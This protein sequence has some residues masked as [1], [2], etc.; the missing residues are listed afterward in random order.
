VVLLARPELLAEPNAGAA[1]DDVEAL[2]AR[3]ER[4]G[5]VRAD[6]VST[7]RI[8][9]L[10]APLESAGRLYF[11]PPSTMVRETLHPGV[12]KVVVEGHRVA[13][14]DETGIRRLDLSHNAAAEG[15]VDNL[16]IVLRGDLVALRDRFEIDYTS[17]GARWRLA[18]T[19]L[20][21]AVRALIEEIAFEGAGARLISM[22]TLETNGDRSDLDFDRVDLNVVLDPGER[23]ALLSLEATDA[24]AEPGR[25]SE[26]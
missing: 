3:F 14:R 7:Q 1:P 8:T 26:P 9:L 20:S 11:E 10:L 4:V 15:L 25:H 12:S 16:M 24:F 21:R 5:V 2:M 6:F 23:A 18:L 19:P 17:D 13:I 22:S